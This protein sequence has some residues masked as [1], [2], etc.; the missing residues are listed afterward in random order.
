MTGTD[1]ISF[2]KQ[3]VPQVTIGQEP[4]SGVIPFNNAGDFIFG[5]AVAVSGPKPPPAPVAVLPRPI[6]SSDAIE[7]KPRDSKVSGGVT[8]TI[9]ESNGRAIPGAEVTLSNLTTGWSQKVQS[10]NSGSYRFSSVPSGTYS[11]L[12]TV[13]GFKDFSRSVDISPDSAVTAKLELSPFSTGALGWAVGSEGAILRTND[14]GV[15]WTH[16]RIHN[17]KLFNA[18]AFAT[19]QL[20]WAVGANGL[21]VHTTDGGDIWNPQYSGTNENLR[22]VCFL[23]QQSGWAIGDQGVLLQTDNGGNTWKA[24]DLSRVGPS[25]WTTDMDSVTFSSPRSGWIVAGYGVL[26][27]EDAGLTW[28][29]VSL[30]KMDFPKAIFFKTPLLGWAAGNDAE[31]ARIVLQTINGGFEWTRQW[32]QGLPKRKKGDLSIKELGER[33]RSFRSIFFATPL[34]GWIVGR[35]DFILH[36]ENGGRDWWPQHIP[37]STELHSITFTTPQLGW[38]VGDEGVVLYTDDGG[39]TWKNQA[40]PNVSTIR[41][42]ASVA[43]N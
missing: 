11:I 28:K 24:F 38:A 14:N 10:D 18:V 13:Q 7:N 42:T 25:S 29:T 19:P 34:E 37:V 31:G 3:S 33:T 27:T 4:D 41:G 1:V 23:S 20:G 22:S 15:N 36:T 6:V 43:A 35:F 40:I 9:T 16:Q 5:R 2:V 26:H 32:S 17:A 8:G 21:I 39:H 30:E 12:V